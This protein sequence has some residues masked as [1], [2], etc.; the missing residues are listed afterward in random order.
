MKKPSKWYNDFLDLPR[1]LESARMLH[2]MIRNGRY[3]TETDI[4]E[5]AELGISLEEV[6]EGRVL[7]SD[8]EDY[9]RIYYKYSS[10]FGQLLYSED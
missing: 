6:L 8:P 1:Q 9:K 7:G 4:A 3:V 5:A 2:R 10:E